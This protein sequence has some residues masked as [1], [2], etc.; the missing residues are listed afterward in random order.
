MTSS[1]FETAADTGKTRRRIVLLSAVMAGLTALGACAGNQGVIYNKNFTAGYSPD[2]L[3]ALR[4]P[5]LVETFGAPV[6]GV[7]QAAVTAS[8]V[9]GLRAS[10][11]RW[12]RFGYSGNP[13]DAP[14]PPYRLRF[15]Y[16]AET[17]FSRQDFCK[18]D[19][20][21]GN[22]STDGSSA[23]AVVALCRGERFVSIAEG[24]PGLG[25]DIGSERFSNFVGAI[26]RQV[27]PRE[28]PVLDDEC[29]FRVCG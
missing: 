16:G 12:A 24:S 25:T 17:G 22:V 5:L 21:P 29:L 9:E 19:R 1:R 26:G 7:S 11:P 20:E 3:A 23:R 10:G 28:N 18:T 2:S 8:T 15:A 4:T 27:M 6:A 13:G 14:N